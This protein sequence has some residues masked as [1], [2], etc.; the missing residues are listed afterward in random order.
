MK[1]NIL[2]YKKSLFIFMGSLLILVIIYY[3]KPIEISLDYPAVMYKEEMYTNTSVEL[4]IIIRRQLFSKDRIDGSILV[5]DKSYVVSN[6]RIYYEDEMIPVTDP[7]SLSQIL[8]EKIY[9]KTL[10]I[11]HRTP[12]QMILSVEITRD[13]KYLYGTLVTEGE[14]RNFIAPAKSWEDVKLISK[15]LFQES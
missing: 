6:N 14:T 10:Y 11:N 8:R 5:G 15:V 12:E 4:K 9:D 7:R 1:K 13:F 3:H 2:K